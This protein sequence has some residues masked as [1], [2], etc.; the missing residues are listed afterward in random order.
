MLLHVSNSCLY[1]LML[2]QLSSLIFPLINEE[3]ERPTFFA[4]NLTAHE[5]LIYNIVQTSLFISK[6]SLIGG[7]IDGSKFISLANG[8]FGLIHH[9]CRCEWT[10]A[11]LYT[12]NK[13][14]RQMNC[15]LGS[16][17]SLWN[18]FMKT[19]LREEKNSYC[20]GKCD[21]KFYYVLVSFIS[22]KWRVWRQNNILIIMQSLMWQSQK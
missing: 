8:S 17:H 5:I 22:L 12:Y 6:A 4:K 7:L 1:S 20:G 14:F 3:K 11:V 19:V 21:P 10:C 15:S 18:V 13:A 9:P 16:M 2:C